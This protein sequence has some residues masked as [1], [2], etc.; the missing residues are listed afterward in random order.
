MFVAG[1][2]EGQ[3]RLEGAGEGFLVLVWMGGAEIE[4]HGGDFWGMGGDGKGEVMCGVC[5]GWWTNGAAWAKVS[6]H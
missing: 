3:F 1:E 4:C 6:G 5:S 2:G